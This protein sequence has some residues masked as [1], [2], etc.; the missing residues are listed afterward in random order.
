MAQPRGHLAPETG[1]A[2]SDG[3]TSWGNAAA[4]PAWHWRAGGR[5]CT[6][7]GKTCRVRLAGLRGPRTHRAR[8]TD[9]MLV[10]G[11]K[12]CARVATHGESWTNAPLQEIQQYRRGIQLRLQVDDLA[13]TM[14]LCAEHA[15]ELAAVAWEPLLHKLD[16]WGWRGVRGLPLVDEEPDSTT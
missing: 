8:Q 16:S 4:L 12:G 3:E 9:Q 1:W 14:Q 15:Q 13:V 11:V 6:S 10:C 2:R 5:E 7:A